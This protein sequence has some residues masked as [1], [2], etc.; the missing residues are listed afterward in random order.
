M[1]MDPSDESLTLSPLQKVSFTSAH[2]PGDVIQG[3]LTSSYLHHI[4]NLFISSCWFLRLFLVQTY[5]LCD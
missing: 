2:L 1:K 3:I 5:E 4:S